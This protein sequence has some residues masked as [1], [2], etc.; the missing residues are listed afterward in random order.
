MHAHI[1]THINTGTYTYT[2]AYTHMIYE[3][4]PAGKLSFFIIV[5]RWPQNSR[6][7]PFGVLLPWAILFESISTSVLFFLFE[8]FLLAFEGKGN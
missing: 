8:L 3:C 1:F 6:V 7:I 5:N 2:H 4:S